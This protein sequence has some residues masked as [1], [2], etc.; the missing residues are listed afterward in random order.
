MQQTRQGDL[1]TNLSSSQLS[2]SS[3]EIFTKR[4]T[5]YFNAFC[6]LL[7]RNFY[8]YIAYLAFDH[9]PTLTV[10][11]SRGSAVTWVLVR[12]PFAV[13]SRVTLLGRLVSTTQF[14]LLVPSWFLPFVVIQV[15][16]SLFPGNGRLLMHEYPWN[17]A[18]EL[19]L[20]AKALQV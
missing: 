6:Y 14:P 16:G 17:I 20:L 5:L 19:K 4:F 7:S 10:I 9:S 2:C 18:F 11:I 12:F 1:F 15:N 3:H 13:G 8:F